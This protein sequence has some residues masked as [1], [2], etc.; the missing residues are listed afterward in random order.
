MTAATPSTS[1]ISPVKTFALPFFT[2]LPFACAT[3]AMTMR[4]GVTVTSSFSPERMPAALLMAKLSADT[5]YCLLAESEPAA[6]ISRLNDLV[7]R[8]TSRTDRFV[9]LMG[10]VLDPAAEAVTLVNAGR[11]APLLYRRAT[12]KW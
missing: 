7:Y 10:A 5:R 8:H 1:G 2:I 6:A 3:G 9:T 4:P 12:G 11:L